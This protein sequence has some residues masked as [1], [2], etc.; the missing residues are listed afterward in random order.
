[1]PSHSPHIA[2][3]RSSSLAICLAIGICQVGHAEL[4]PT[5]SR[6]RHRDELTLVAAWF[7]LVLG[8][9]R[10]RRYMRG[11]VVGR[12][13]WNTRPALVRLGSGDSLH[14][15]TAGAGRTDLGA[16]VADCDLCSWQYRRCSTI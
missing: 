16:D 13:T 14:A 6:M 5:V 9:N 7:S 15:D 1:M 8:G 11:G 4:E 12:Q 10:L 3:I 2:A